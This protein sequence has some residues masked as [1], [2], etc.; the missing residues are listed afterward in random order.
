MSDILVSIL[1][2]I[3]ALFGLVAALGLVRLPDIYMRMHAATKAGTVG[4][5]FLMMA[6][7]L[8]FD[9]GAVTT[10]ALLVS[11]FFL[12]TSPVAAHMIGDVAH[13]LG[14]KAWTQDDD[15]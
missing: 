10:R 6:V 13:K 1:M 2:L 8:Y 5:L 3:G 9:D 7:A 15:A 4:V 12:L 14:I 11:A